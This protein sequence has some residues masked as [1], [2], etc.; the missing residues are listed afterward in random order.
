LIYLSATGS[1]LISYPVAT[2]R[3]NQHGFQPIS[4]QIT[5]EFGARQL[6]GGDTG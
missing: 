6:T 5:I 3:R 2:A 4:Q 1:N